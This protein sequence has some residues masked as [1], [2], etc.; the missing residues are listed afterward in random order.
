MAIA[1]AAVSAI[2][3]AILT[4]ILGAM[5]VPAQPMDVDFHQCRSRSFT[6]RV[7]RNLTVLKPELATTQATASR[8]FLKVSGVVGLVGVV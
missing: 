6:S 2:W 4:G 7:S 5:P 1:A 8:D 3:S